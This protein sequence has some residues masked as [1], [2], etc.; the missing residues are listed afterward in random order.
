MDNLTI[1]V[2]IDSQTPPEVA[3]VDENFTAVKTKVDEIVA[4]VNAMGG[5]S[6]TMTCTDFS[7]SQAN[8][9]YYVKNGNQVTLYIPAFTGTSNS[10]NFILSGIP[11]AIRPIRQQRFHVHFVTDNTSN[12]YYGEFLILTDGTA[13]HQLLTAPGAYG[14]FT[15]SGTKTSAAITVTYLLT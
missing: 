4:V 1:P 9:A 6:F 5:S 7:V 2:T 11:A 3:H 8:T 12:K 10:A 15:A 14:S 13:Y